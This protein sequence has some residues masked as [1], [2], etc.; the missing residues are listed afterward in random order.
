MRLILKCSVYRNNAIV[1]F[2]FMD[3][4]GQGPHMETYGHQILGDLSRMN[5]NTTIKVPKGQV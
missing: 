4:V 1:H 2:N 5:Q 3:E